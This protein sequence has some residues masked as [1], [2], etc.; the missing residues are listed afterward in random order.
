MRW[1]LK[2]RQAEEVPGSED[3]HPEDAGGFWDE[4]F[5]SVEPPYVTLLERSKGGPYYLAPDSAEPLPS[6][7]WSNLDPQAVEQEAQRM[8]RLLGGEWRMGIV[9]PSLRE[10]LLSDGSAGRRIVEALEGPAPRADWRSP[11]HSD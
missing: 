11:K 5:P 6:G 9:E 4:Q 2:K 3:G 7:M 10:S 8:T 1:K